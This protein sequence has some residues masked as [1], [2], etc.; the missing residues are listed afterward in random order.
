MKTHF[1]LLLPIHDN[2]LLFV[3]EALYMSYSFLHIP[4]SLQKINSAGKR[5][6]RNSTENAFL[7]LTIHR[8]QWINMLLCNSVHEII[9]III[10]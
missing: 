6:Q 7:A 3:D 1:Q 5:S 8:R 10:I 9:Y 2:I 4:Y